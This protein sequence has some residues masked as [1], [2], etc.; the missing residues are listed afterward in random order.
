MKFDD[1]GL[2]AISLIAA[3]GLES[4]KGVR[5]VMNRLAETVGPDNRIVD[6]EK[7]AREREQRILRGY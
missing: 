1:I 4:E 7:L 5:N 2:L 6:Y 3:A